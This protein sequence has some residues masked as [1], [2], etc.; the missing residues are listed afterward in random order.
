[1]NPMQIHLIKTYYPHWHEHTAFNAFLK[2]F[3]PPGFKISM[4]SVPMGDGRFPPIPFLKKYCREKIKKQGVPQ[5][6]LNDLV[7]EISVFFTTII[8]RAD[9]VHFLDA[10]H[11]LLF[12]PYWYEKW[13]R[14]KFF[15][16]IVA[17]F[18]QPPAILDSLINIDIVRQV[19][20]VVV[21]FPALFTGGT[22]NH[23]PAGSRHAVF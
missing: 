6:R 7:A 15:P 2:Y 1:M 14:L 4:R 16:K 23:D 5:Y 9:A 17:M 12:L 10:E 11:S 18:H 19:D 21:V 3:D 13:K 20:R 22:G 8:K